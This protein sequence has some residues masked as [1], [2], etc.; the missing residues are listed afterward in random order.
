VPRHGYVL[1]LPAAGR[2]REILNTDAG[3]YGGSG[4]GNMGAVVAVPESSH[5]KPAHTK[6]TLPP[7]A[8]LYFMLDS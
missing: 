3:E 4:L 1:P 5:G 6:V 2:W 7:L 8:T